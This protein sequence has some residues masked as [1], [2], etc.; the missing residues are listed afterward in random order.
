MI[1]KPNSRL[2]TQQ[3]ELFHILSLNVLGKASESAGRG[4]T[5]EGIGSEERR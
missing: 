4:G 3:R 5:D 1:T 2:S